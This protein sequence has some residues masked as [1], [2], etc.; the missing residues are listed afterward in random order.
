MLMTSIASVLTGTTP[1][2][3]HLVHAKLHGQVTT[4]L[5]SYAVIKMLLSLHLS[6]GATGTLTWHFRISDP[7]I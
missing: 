3:T 6:D 7:I 4:T 1:A 2:P 5:L